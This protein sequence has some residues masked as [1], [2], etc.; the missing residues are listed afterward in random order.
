MKKPSTVSKSNSTITR[1]RLNGKNFQVAWATKQQMSELSGQYGRDGEAHLGL[2]DPAKGFIAVR[3]DLH[4][5]E[6]KD[7][8]LHEVLHMIDLQNDTNLHE[9][10]VRLTATDLMGWMR[11]NPDIVAWIMKEE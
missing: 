6:Q 10:Q 2:A 1:F 5:D 11:D 8:L 9:V 3:N 4:L 7:T